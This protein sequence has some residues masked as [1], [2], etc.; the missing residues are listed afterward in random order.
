[1]EYLGIIASLLGGGFIGNFF[2]L[3][4]TRLKAKSEAFAYELDNTQEAIKIWRETAEAL[5]SEISELRKKNES[6][7]KELECLRKA[8][9]R[10]TTINNR[11]VK[12]LDKITPENLETM[13][14]QIKKMHDES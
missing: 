5:K 9:N 14:E 1:M 10:L 12:L 6:M 2:T 8:V 13:V 11:M 7:Q 4:F 3:K